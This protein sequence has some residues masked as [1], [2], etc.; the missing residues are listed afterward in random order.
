MF[1]AYKR[2][3]AYD[4]LKRYIIADLVVDMRAS[5]RTLRQAQ[6][7]LAERENRSADITIDLDLADLMARNPKYTDADMLEYL[8]SG[9]LFSREVLKF[10]GYYI[11]ASAVILN[12]KAYLFTAPSGTGKSTHTEKWCSLFGARYL[13][14]DKPVLRRMDE[15]W[16]AYGTPW[17]GKF[18]KSSNE[19][20]E[21]G[22]IACLSRDRENRIAPMPTEQAIPFLMGQSIFRLDRE[23]TERKLMLLDRLL[24]E[25]P[26]WQLACRNDDA[27]AVMARNVMTSERK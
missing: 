22:G 21:V 18:D 10:D 12:E 15:K 6:P 1:L 8:A 2:G 25:V 19:G 7:Y 17:S 26:V 9:L 20:V 16:M 23:Q 14:D 13:N 11:H 5:G 4:P 3:G 24:R 27:A